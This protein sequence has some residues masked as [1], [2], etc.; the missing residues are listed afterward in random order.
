MNKAQWMEETY[1]GQIFR[2]TTEIICII[3]IPRQ[4]IHSTVL[5]L[6]LLLL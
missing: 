6:L 4:S 2:L 1:G 5:L 3:I